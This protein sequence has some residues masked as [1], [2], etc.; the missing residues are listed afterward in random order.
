[1]GESMP[2]PDDLEKLL[3]DV[4][5]TISDNRQFLE[6][7]VDETVEED[8]GEDTETRVAEEDFEEL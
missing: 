4:R 2:E 3:L 7:L 1:M 5:K 8:S 6:K